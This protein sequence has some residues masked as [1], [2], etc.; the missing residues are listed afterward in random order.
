MTNTRQPY[1]FGFADS[2]L[3]ESG[4]APLDALHSDVDAICRC[5]EAVVPLAE[6][7]GV[8]P[9]RP[10]LA[11]RIDDL[12]E[13]ADYLSQG[14]VPDRLAALEALLERR[15]DAARSIG[16]MYEGPVTTAALMM[17]PD[18]FVLPYEDPRRAHALL[19]FCTDSAANYANAIQERLVGSLEPNG[20]VGIPDDF[21]GILPAAMFGEF[22]APYWD[23]LYQRLGATERHLHSELLR[24]EHLPYLRDLEI[25]AFDPSADQYVTPELLRERCPVPFTG[26]V[27]SWDM[28]DNTPDAL[29]LL[30]RRI[31]QYEPVSISFYMDT[32]AIEEKAVALLEVARELANEENS[33]HKRVQ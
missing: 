13:P 30:Y 9:P 31:A 27:Q 32:V 7:L 21:A 1:S 16:H 22:V 17:G 25:A 18:F 6:R 24:P 5:Y 33:G 15:P 19:R 20:P 12:S 29:Q 23:R 2:L 4:E 8:K 10:R 14:V 26:R 11:E 3:A 28:R